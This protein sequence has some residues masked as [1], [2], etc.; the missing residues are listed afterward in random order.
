LREAEEEGRRVFLEVSLKH[1]ECLP[2]FGLTH[3]L[4]VHAAKWE[5]MPRVGKT[6]HTWLCLVLEVLWAPC[7]SLHWPEMSKRSVQEMQKLRFPFTAYH[8]L[9]HSLSSK[10]QLLRLEFSKMV[11]YVL[12]IIN[13][14]LQENSP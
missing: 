6:C 10:A 3:S 13:Y 8:V 4:T 7:L 11:R 5:P 14:N 2:G 9:L 12:F 1:S